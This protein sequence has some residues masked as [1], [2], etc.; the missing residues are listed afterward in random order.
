MRGAM[1]GHLT[2]LGADSSAGVS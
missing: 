2:V 1:Q